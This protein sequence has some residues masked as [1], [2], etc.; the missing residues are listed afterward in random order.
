LNTPC[1]LENCSS[2]CSA[3]GGPSLEEGSGIEDG[4]LDNSADSH[5]SQSLC[6]STDYESVDYGEVD[7]EGGSEQWH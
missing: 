4:R 1:N 7:S 2:Q 5:I 6:L 3:F